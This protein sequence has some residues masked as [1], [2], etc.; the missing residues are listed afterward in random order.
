MGPPAS[1]VNSAS[2]MKSA[3]KTVSKLLT[4][5]AKIVSNMLSAGNQF[6]LFFNISINN[7]D[8]SVLMLV[9]LL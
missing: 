4:C 5:F 8:F 9:M 1:A 6:Q 2:K 3:A 7:H